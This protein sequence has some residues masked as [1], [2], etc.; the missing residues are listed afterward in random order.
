MKN[1]VID[2]FVK[3]FTH[4]RWVVAA[5]ILS[6]GCAFWVYGC[7]PKTTSPFTGAQVTAVEL[8]QQVLSEEEA[9][10]AEG[11][12][13][14]AAVITYNS[15]V[16]I[17]GAKTEQSRMD[18]QRQYEV[19]KKIIDVI[20]GFATGLITGDVS[21]TNAV[22]ALTLISSI[23]VGGGL[24]VNGKRKDKVIDSN[25]EKKKTK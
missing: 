20:G 1:D 22:G 17:F 5:M 24:Y 21:P 11:A 2:K 25:D 14:D 8:E 10:K 3:W 15:K 19:K 18:L 6:M 12:E 16:E 13:L 4:N 9:L 7:E 23:L